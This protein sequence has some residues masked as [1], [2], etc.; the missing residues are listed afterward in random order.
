MALN[1]RR[2]AFR[3]PTGESSLTRLTRVKNLIEAYKDGRQPS[4]ILVIKALIEYHELLK[5]LWL[6]GLKK[7]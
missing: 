6:W 1:T 4:K 3:L 5:S 2:R 7:Q